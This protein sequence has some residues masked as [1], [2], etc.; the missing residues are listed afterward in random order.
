MVG[1][2]Q[3]VTIGWKVERVSGEVEFVPGIVG[4]KDAKKK[5]IPSPQK[6]TTTGGR[7]C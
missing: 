5:L 6:D 4:E 2:P 1:S 3:K 7:A